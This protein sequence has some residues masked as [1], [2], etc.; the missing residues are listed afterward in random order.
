[1]LYASSSEIIHNR[2]T[3]LLGLL[4]TLILFLYNGLTISNIPILEWNTL[5]LHEIKLIDNGMCGLTQNKLTGLSLFELF[6]WQ[7]IYPDTYNTCMCWIDT[8][9][10]K[11]HIFVSF[12]DTDAA[13]IGKVIH[14]EK[15]RKYCS[16]LYR[17]CILGDALK[18]NMLA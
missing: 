13:L 16:I 7:E 18:K 1:M 6:L 8:G 14:I 4:K 11:I 3:L 12:R 15:S 10:F 9:A 5:V 2:C 17:Q